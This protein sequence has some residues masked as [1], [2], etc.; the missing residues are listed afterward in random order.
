MS[1]IIW[2]GYAYRKKDDPSKYLME[3]DLDSGGSERR[4]VLRMDP[5]EDDH[6]LEKAYE[7]IKVVL[8]EG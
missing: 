5:L 3:N 6:L 2:R 4:L 8:S 1:K 7:E